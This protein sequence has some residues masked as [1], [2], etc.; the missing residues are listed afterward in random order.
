MFLCFLDDLQQIGYISLV[1]GGFSH[2]TID[3]NVRESFII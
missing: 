2:D 1:K 3:S